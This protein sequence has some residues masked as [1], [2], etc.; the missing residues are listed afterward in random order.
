MVG[1]HSLVPRSK[2]RSKRE[3]SLDQGQR[4]EAGGGSSSPRMRLQAG[5]SEMLHNLL[6]LHWGNNRDWKS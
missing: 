4:Q 5:L 3:N 1:L 2:G 6:S